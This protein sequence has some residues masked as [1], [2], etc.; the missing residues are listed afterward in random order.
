MFFDY[1]IQFVQFMA[2]R[3]VETTETGAWEMQQTSNGIEK[4]EYRD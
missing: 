4:K 1:F 2:V 3:E